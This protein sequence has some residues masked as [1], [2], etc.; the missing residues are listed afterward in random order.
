MVEA[1][2]K[3]TLPEEA[4]RMIIDALSALSRERNVAFNICSDVAQAK[5]R[6]L[7]ERSDFELHEISNL[8]R[9]FGGGI[10]N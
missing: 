5:G 7:P 1:D 10:I 9:R 3:D 2:L 4:R 8:A 6:E